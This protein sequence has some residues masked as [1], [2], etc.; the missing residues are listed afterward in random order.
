MQHDSASQITNT[1]IAAK[2][3]WVPASPE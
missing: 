1:I 3:N 2:P